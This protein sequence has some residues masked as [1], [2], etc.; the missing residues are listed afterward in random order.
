MIPEASRVEIKSDI[1]SSLKSNDDLVSLLSD[2]TSSIRPKNTIDKNETVPDNDSLL[3]V[4]I[5]A[6]SSTSRSVN[7][8]DVSYLIQIQVLRSDTHRREN[9][10]LWSDKVHDE[11]SKTLTHFSPAN[12]IANG[13]AGSVE[14][15]W[16]ENRNR[17]MS[18]TSFEFIA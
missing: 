3:L 5:I 7:M 11:I 17:W 16:N 1:L 18:D 9:T 13:S 12:T 2:G 8:A 6:Q 14:E 4:G 15:Q 10:S